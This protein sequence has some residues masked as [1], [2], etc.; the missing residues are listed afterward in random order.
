MHLWRKLLGL[1][2]L[3]IAALLVLTL[4]AQRGEGKAGGNQPIILSTASVNGEISPCG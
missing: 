4:P 2:G 3:G 1:G